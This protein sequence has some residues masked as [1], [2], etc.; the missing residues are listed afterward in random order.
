MI[1]PTALRVFSLDNTATAAFA[2]VA[3]G[4]AIK[5]TTF[6]KKLTKRNLLRIIKRNGCAC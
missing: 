6:H 5:I 4:T 1:H 2:I 3:I